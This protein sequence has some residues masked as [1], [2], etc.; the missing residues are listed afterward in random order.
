MLDTLR[1]SR[2]GAGAKFR[3]E[4]NSAFT[5]FTKYERGEFLSSGNIG[6]RFDGSRTDTRTAD[7]HDL[8]AWER[9]AI[10]DVRLAE[11]AGTVEC[12]NG[13]AGADADTSPL[14]AGGSQQCSKPETAI[15][16]WQAGYAGFQCF[17]QGSRGGAQVRVLRVCTQA[18]KN[19]YASISNAEENLPLLYLIDHESR[20][21]RIAVFPHVP[22]E[23]PNN[24]SKRASGYHRKPVGKEPLPQAGLDCSQANEVRCARHRQRA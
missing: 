15:W 22:D 7:D 8:H 5:I 23:L 9:N 6:L 11:V 4:I 17:A 12:A 2:Q 1:T 18:R 10:R 16:S 21:G 19:A 24:A 13:L 3:G 14:V 20:R